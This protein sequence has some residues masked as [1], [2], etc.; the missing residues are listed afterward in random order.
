MTTENNFPETADIETSTD[1]YANRFSGGTGAW[2]LEVQEKITLD[3]IQPSKEKKVLDVGGGHGQLSIPLCR[4]G[5]NVTVLSSAESCRHRISG[6]IDDGKCK[7]DIG[8]IIE[9]PYKDNSF[10]SVICF[11]LLTHC[12]Q[13]PKLVEELCRVSAG[14]I[15]VDYPTS[16]SLNK[17]APMLFKAKK[18]FEGDTRSW[19]LFKHKEVINEFKKNGYI[20]KR[21]KAQFFIPMV[22][23]RAFKSPIISKVLEG[24]CRILGLTHFWGSPMIVKFEK[25]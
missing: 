19:K 2:M 23:H 21:K 6:I 4:D 25:N 7:F 8:N 3:M 24:I 22:L 5:Y 11:R 14:N 17:I 20:V 12:E 15:I 1:Q 10:E 9:L 16:Q 18:K 13:W